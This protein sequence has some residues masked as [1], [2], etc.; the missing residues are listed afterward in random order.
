MNPLIKSI[1]H[2]KIELDEANITLRDYIDYMNLMLNV[3]D[4]AKK[5]AEEKAKKEAILLKP[6]KELTEQFRKERGI[7]LDDEGA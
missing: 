6:S 7:P 1:R 3:E 2:L 4:R 5:E